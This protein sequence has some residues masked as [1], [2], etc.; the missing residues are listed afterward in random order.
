MR[1]YAT[2]TQDRIVRLEETVRLRHLGVDPDALSIE[3]LIALRFA[4]GAETVAIEE[5]AK[6]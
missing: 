2:Y 4:P 1:K 5:K 3:Q 6:Q